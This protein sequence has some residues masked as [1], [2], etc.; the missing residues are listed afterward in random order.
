MQSPD[1]ERDEFGVLGI[2]RNI[3]KITIMKYNSK[4]QSETGFCPLRRLSFTLRL[5]NLVNY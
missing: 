2:L 4:F 1:Y 5:M 3:F